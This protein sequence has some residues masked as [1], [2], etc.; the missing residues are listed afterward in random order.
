MKYRI[1]GNSVVLADGK[2]VEFAHAVGE[3]TDLGDML[4][5][6]LQ[7]PND[8]SFQENVFAV[9]PQGEIL[10]QIEPNPS[11]SSPEYLY[12]QVMRFD[13]TAIH[14]W[15]Y[16]CDVVEVEKSTGKVLGSEFIK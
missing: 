10:W 1:D 7:P 5:V 8:V 4:L 13:D 9:S 3:V 15:N 6:L 11:S 2:R 12:T 16:S 14:L